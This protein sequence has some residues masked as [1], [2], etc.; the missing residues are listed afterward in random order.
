MRSHCI[1]EWH[2]EDC[3]AGSISDLNNRIAP[4]VIH[5]AHELP[6]HFQSFDD[7][8][9]QVGQLCAVR[10]YLKLVTVS[11]VEIVQGHHGKQPALGEECR[12]QVTSAQPQQKEVEDTWIA[13]SI[14]K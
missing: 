14:S 12:P 7:C 1:R 4:Q 2:G 5:F 8:G 13:P 10:I 11:D 9:I 6:C 3:F